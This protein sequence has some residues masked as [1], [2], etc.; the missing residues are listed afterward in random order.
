MHD[1]MYNTII[2]IA[3]EALIVG[4]QRPFFTLV[5]S[6]FLSWPTLSIVSEEGHSRYGYRHNESHIISDLVFPAH[7]A[8]DKT[9]RPA[10]ADA[11]GLSVYRG[12]RIAVSRPGD[13]TIK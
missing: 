9:H 12:V 8:L 10:A 1:L 4:T 6:A 2:G 5:L 3:K 13:P 7:A 11:T